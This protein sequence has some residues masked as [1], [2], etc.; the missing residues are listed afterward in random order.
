MDGP[1]EK[2]K[3]RARGPLWLSLWV[4]VLWGGPGGGLC[5]PSVER[6]APRG[7]TPP[8]RFCWQVIGLALLAPEKGEQRKGARRTLQGTGKG[9]AQGCFVVFVV[10]FRLE[11]TNTP[12]WQRAFGGLYH[13]GR[14]I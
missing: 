4:C 11:T 2:F 8:R 10:E 12:L 14:A 9:G 6:P 1:E 13:C 3:V 5:W 7:N